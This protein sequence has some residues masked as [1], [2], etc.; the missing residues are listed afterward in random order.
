MRT[1]VTLIIC[2]LLLGGVGG[3][4]VILKKNQ[5][6]AAKVEKP[7]LV[8]TVEVFAS[9]A[10]DINLQLPSQGIVMPRRTT[11]L[12]AEVPGRVGSVSERFKVGER[13]ETGDILLE[14]DSADYDSAVVQSEAALAEAKASLMQEAA[15]ADQAKRDW[16]K[17]AAGQT[18]SDL[19]MRKPQMLSAEARV[20][21][22]EDNLTK[23]RR[24]LE[25][26]KIKAPFGGRIRATHTEVG[27]YLMPGAPV[28]DFDS[29]GKLEVR[30]PLSIDD[31]SFMAPGSSGSAM[32]VCFDLEVAGKPYTWKGRIV[33]NEG[34]VER[35]SRS[36]YLVAEIDEESDQ[37]GGL[38]QPGLFVQARIAGRTL[39][40]VHRIPRKAFLDT[41]RTERDAAPDASNTERLALVGPDDTIVIRKVTVVRHLGTDLLV[42]SGLKD[43]DR[44]CLTALPGLVDGMKVLSKEAQPPALTEDSKPNVLP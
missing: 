23:A 4:L 20:L 29:T 39:S 3:T 31:L 17:L 16:D 1:I 5:P 37:S 18:P 8:P 22:A 36:T 14:I 28:V 24:D 33:R 34:E 42:D 21:A 15:R 38:L 19:A 43:G 30:L 10:V 12:A 44:V 7:K 25:R 27:S 32:E 6:E 35:A 41:G 26:I 2:L 9:K 40:G 11:V 13:F